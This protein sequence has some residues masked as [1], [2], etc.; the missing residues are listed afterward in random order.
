MP[1][2]TE[3]M[4]NEAQ[5]GLDWRREF[6]RG[7]TEVGIARARDIS[8]KRDL[9]M[10]T[11]RRM[12]SY[13]ARHEVDKE[14]EGFRQ[15]EDGYPSNGR[16]AWALW[17]GDAG[18]AWAK[19][20][21]DQDESDRSDSSSV[22]EQNVIHSQQGL[23]TDMAKTEIRALSESV[24]IR[25]EEGDVS[26]AGYAAVFGEETNIGGAFIEVIERGAFKN[27]IERGDDVV[28][29]INHDG[30]PLARTRSGTLKLTEDE[31]GLYIE[32]KLDSS[33]PDVKSILPKMKRGDLDKMSFAFI[34]DVQTWDD[35]GD[36][37]KRII[38]DVRMYDVSIVT[39]P[40]YDG[41][42][43]GLR[44]LERFREENKKSQAA[45]R[46]RMKSRL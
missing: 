23:E 6:G 19:R 29:L 45:R 26:V 39:T 24:E 27:A 20:M 5:R 1:K 30:L 46:L 37:P 16:I 15:G 35:S 18:Q 41:T 44:S 33:D 34:P 7:G 28:F 13:F 9:S 17:G 43:I 2:P 40:A 10:E 38:R 14:A 25:A 11:V 22:T 12:N 4:A 36:M 31:R 21:I 32:T 3:A 42:E 8:N